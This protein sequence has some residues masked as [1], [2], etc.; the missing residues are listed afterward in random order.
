M[1]LNSS[2]VINTAGYPADFFV[3]ATPTVTSVS[4]AL[5]GQFAGVVAAPDAE[6]TVNAGGGSPNDY[7]GALIGRSVRL[8]GP[9]GFHYDESLALNRLW[10]VGPAT[11]AVLTAASAGP[12]GFHF[13][14]SGGRR[15]LCL[16]GSGVG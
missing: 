8:N 14:V 5:D 15:W 2:G 11:P 10:P 13:V 16:S 7:S 1:W 6:I 4:I 12:N 9:L 3:L